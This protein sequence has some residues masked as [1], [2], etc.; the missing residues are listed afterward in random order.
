[1]ILTESADRFVDTFAPEHSEIQ[2]EMA[3]IAETEGF[4]IIGQAAGGVLQLLAARGSA[5]RVFEF[6]SGFG[7]SATWFLEGMAPAGEIV[8]TEIDEDE[9]MMAEEFLT[10]AAFDATI[11]YEHGDALA[12]VEQYEG[13]FDVVLIDHRKQD[14][15][16]AFERIEPKVSTGGVVVAD[17]IMNGPVTHE[18]I[19]DGLDRSE[20]EDDIV[21]GF[22]TYLDRVRTHPDWE[23]IVLPVGNGLVVSVKLPA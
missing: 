1:M 6:G 14:Y 23:T 22:L 12:I 15:A 21:S 11:Q 5:Q 17:N 7:Y 8:L 9:L 16:A 20:P 18:D 2:A 13:P 3:E 4:P 19:L 10:E